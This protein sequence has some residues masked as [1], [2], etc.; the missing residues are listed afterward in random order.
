MGC[1]G[2]KDSPAPP[3][4]VVE[5]HS[6]APVVE[7]ELKSPSAPVPPPPP[8]P[9]PQQ[10][11]TTNGSAGANS[12][13]DGLLDSAK[14]SVTPPP[15]SLPSSLPPT[16]ATASPPVSEARS[17][18]PPPPPPPPKRE[19]ASP[20]VPTPQTPHP[21][22]TP[23]TDSS[24]NVSSKP[25]GADRSPDTIPEA[26]SPVAKSAASQSPIHTQPEAKLEDDEPLHVT[27]LVGFVLK[28]KRTDQSKVFV[29]VMYHGVV[30]SM[31]SAP[32][33][34]SSDK[35]GGQCEAYDIIVPRQ[36]YYDAVKDEMF[37]DQVNIF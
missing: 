25:A 8:P 35:K 17:P 19:V 9:P 11:K 2:S 7:V 1:G 37:R 10:P 20:V 33:R 4:V 18:P 15:L 24:V 27:P 28:T 26:G 36:I 23:V 12:Q 31:L 13:A 21:D 22:P 5:Q 29:N 32:A 30:L 34:T 6:P 16:L 3:Q 14:V